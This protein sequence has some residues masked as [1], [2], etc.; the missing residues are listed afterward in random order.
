MEQQMIHSS[1]VCSCKS[2]EPCF[3]QAIEE[4]LHRS[5]GEFKEVLLAKLDGIAKQCGYEKG[6][7]GDWIQFPKQ[8]RALESL[9]TKYEIIKEHDD[10][11]L[12][13][14]I[15]EHHAMAVVTTEGEVFTKPD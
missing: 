8:E 15:P 7:K 6:E 5:P 10:G 2:I 9:G 13:I 3:L 14:K 11:D 12:T 1:L 4:N